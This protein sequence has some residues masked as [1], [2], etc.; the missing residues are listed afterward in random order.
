[1][2]DYACWHRVDDDFFAENDWLL[3]MAKLFKVALPMMQFTNNV[4][5]DYE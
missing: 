3:P 5:D 1:M 4:I 2:K